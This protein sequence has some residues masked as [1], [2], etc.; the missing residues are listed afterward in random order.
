MTL[1]LDKRRGPSGRFVLRLPRAATTPAAPA[2]PATPT[3][4]PATPPTRLDPFDVL[5]H[6]PRRRATRAQIEMLAAK[7]RAK[8]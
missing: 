1:N 5:R 2:A 4:P 6:A 8:R 7:W 3:T